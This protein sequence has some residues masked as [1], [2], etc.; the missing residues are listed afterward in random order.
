MRGNHLPLRYR[1]KVAD[2]GIGHLLLEKGCG[3]IINGMR[4]GGDYQAN[5][6]AKTQ[7]DKILLQQL[8]SWTKNNE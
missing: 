2:H 1:E 3:L 4:T 6:A 8:E 5:E 7:S